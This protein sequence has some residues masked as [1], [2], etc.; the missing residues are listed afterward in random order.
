VRTEPAAARIAG[1]TPLPAP[2][3]EGAPPSCFCWVTGDEGA[4]DPPAAAAAPGEGEPRGREREGEV[5]SVPR[6]GLLA[7][8]GLGSAWGGGRLRCACSSSN[9]NADDD[10]DDADEGG[11]GGDSW[12]E[13]GVNVIEG[14]DE[15]EGPET[16]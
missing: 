13:G 5:G 1:W 11:G 7:S 15:D 4:E 16:T 12:G 6:R 14:D 9:E 3:M 2:L 10:A 8:I